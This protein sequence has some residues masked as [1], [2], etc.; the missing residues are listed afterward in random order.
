MKIPKGW[1]RVPR[2]C[3]LREGDR[4]FRNWAFRPGWEDITVFSDCDGILKA[5]GYEH[6]IRK[7]AR[8]P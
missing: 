8:K 4:V 5:S 1:R 6:I 3:R 2:G 7:K